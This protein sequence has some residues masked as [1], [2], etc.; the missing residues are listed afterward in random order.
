MRAAI[1]RLLHRG[2]HGGSPYSLVFRKTVSYDAMKSVPAPSGY[3]ELMDR[4][5]TF[6]AP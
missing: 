4:V 6:S 1:A 2:S 3:F 5:P